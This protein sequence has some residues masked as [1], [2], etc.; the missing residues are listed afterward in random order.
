[1]DYVTF[2]ESILAKLGSI[3]PDEYVSAVFSVYR[4]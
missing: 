3:L 4:I 1:M 2:C